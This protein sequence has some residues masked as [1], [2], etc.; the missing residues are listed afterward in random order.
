MY[1]DSQESAYIG[2][3]FLRCTASSVCSAYKL[4]DVNL[5]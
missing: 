5:V 3:L 1:E 2:A 4:T